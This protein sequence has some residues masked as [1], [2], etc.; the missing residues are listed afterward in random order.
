MN[1]K[2]KKIIFN[3]F[4]ALSIISI[5]SIIF[6]G[7]F[8]SNILNKDFYNELYGKTRAYGRIEKEIVDAKTDELFLFFENNGQLDKTFYTEN[9]I[10]HMNDVKILIKKFTTAYYVSIIL[11]IFSMIVIY[12]ISRKEMLDFVLKSLFYSGV[13]SLVLILLFFI[14]SFSSV[15]DNFHRIFFTGNYTFPY[16]SHLIMMFNEQFFMLFAQKI[17]IITGLKA[18]ILSSVG[19]YF[20]FRKKA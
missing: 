6:I 18:I 3:S 2:K 7:S 13:I 9:E 4:L 19:S 16:D 8:L 17:F 15:F 20:I 14:L 5:I 12:N 11:L 1:L 10:S